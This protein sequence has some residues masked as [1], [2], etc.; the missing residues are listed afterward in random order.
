[1]LYCSGF[2]MNSAQRSKNRVGI[3]AVSGIGHR[4]KISVGGNFMIDDL[5]AWPAVNV[6]HMCV[7]GDRAKIS[8]EWPVATPADGQH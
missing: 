3:K 8:T 7:V 5:L 1:M 6:F 2:V 4:F